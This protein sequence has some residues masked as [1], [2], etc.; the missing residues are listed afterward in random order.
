MGDLTFSSFAMICIF[1]S[2][3]SCGQVLIKLS[4]GKKVLMAGSPVS[5]LMNIVR[6]F[7]HPLMLAGLGLYVLGTLIWILVL[8][9]VRLSVAYPMMSMSYFLVVILSALV[10]RERVK[11]RYAVAG[12][13]LISGGVSLIGIGMG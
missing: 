1:V 2:M 7:F 13:V 3:I 12:L 10:L 6:S 11:W 9:R 8:S 4:L 5:T